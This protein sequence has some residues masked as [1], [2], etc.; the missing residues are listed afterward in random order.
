[1]LFDF[2]PAESV[3]WIFKAL[4]LAYNLLVLI[5]VISVLLE[6]RPPLKTISWIVVLVFVPVAGLFFYFILGEGIHKHIKFRKKKRNDAE[7][8]REYRR[9][10]MEMMA[11]NPKKDI[12]AIKTKADLIELSLNLENSLLFQ[13]NKI[14][15]LYNGHETYVELINALKKAQNHIHFEYYIF[16]EGDVANE[17]R[18][19]LC[20]KAESGVKVRFIYDGVGSFWLSS[21]FVNSLRESGVEALPFQPV[22][23]PKPLRDIN[24]RNHRKIVVIDGNIGFIG[25]INIS[26]KYLLPDDKLGFWRDTHLKIEGAA[27]HGLQNVFVGDWTFLKK[28]FVPNI[29]SLF[30]PNQVESECFTQIISSGPDTYFHTLKDVFFAAFARAKKNIHI[31]TPYFMPDD[32]ILTAL[33]IASLSGVEVK[34]ILPKRSDAKLV[35]AC[36]RSYIRELLDHGIQVYLYRPG[37]IHCKVILIDGLISSVGTANMDYRS[38]SENME[39][40]AIVYDREVYGK[41]EAQFGQDIQDSDLVVAQEWKQRGKLKKAAES[42]AR[43]FAPLF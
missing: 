9:Q 1:M 2:I 36:T 29:S 12:K 37:F 38:F 4:I 22:R 7:R 21:A 34:V 27:V 35:G 40:N 32:S 33:K 20:Q 14:N 28:D 10:Q 15:V 24:Y 11:G 41:L 26:D 13:K 16:E 43:L 31:C 30:P 17:I 25:G 39:V 19:I 3:N 6:N 18:K 42:V 8:L 5:T 23:F